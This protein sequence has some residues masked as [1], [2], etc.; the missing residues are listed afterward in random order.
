MEEGKWGLHPLIHTPLEFTLVQDV[1]SHKKAEPKLHSGLWEMN[2]L[3]SK[4]TVDCGSPALRQHRR[5]IYPC[6]FCC[7]AHDSRTQCRRPY[8]RFPD[9]VFF[10]ILNREVSSCNLLCWWRRWESNPRP[11]HRNLSLSKLAE[12]RLHSAKN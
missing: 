3:I 1:A 11:Q 2:S 12:F 8:R 10:D 5:P 9:N 7:R 4:S 6:I